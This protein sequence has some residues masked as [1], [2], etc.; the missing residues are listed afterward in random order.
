MLAKLLLP[1]DGFLILISTVSMIFAMRNDGNIPE[2][3]SKLV[4]TQYDSLLQYLDFEGWQEL[5]NI[6]KK[7]R[8]IGT[9]EFLSQL[10]LKPSRMSTKLFPKEGIVKDEE[11]AIKIAEIYWL[12]MFGDVIYKQIPFIAVKIKNDVWYVTSSLPPGY[13]GKVYRMDIKAS[14]GQVLSI[15]FA[16]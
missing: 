15:G 13:S 2:Y 7:D 5:N 9:K 16:R 3:K 11:T 12:G 10:K 1:I 4:T 14:N 6:E 8:I